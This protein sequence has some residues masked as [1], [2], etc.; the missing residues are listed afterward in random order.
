[1]INVCL[2]SGD[3]LSFLSV[4]CWL[5]KAAVLFLNSL[6]NIGDPQSIRPITT[7]NTVLTH[8]GAILVYNP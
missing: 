5:T 7:K 3:S 4:K 2:Y 1:M 6:N 8:N